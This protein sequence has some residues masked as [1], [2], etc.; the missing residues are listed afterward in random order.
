MMDC[1]VLVKGSHT[2]VEPLLWRIAYA[3]PKEWDELDTLQGDWS[4]DRE[5]RALAY[6]EAERNEITQALDAAEITYHIIPEDQPDAELLAKLQNAVTSK[7][8]ALIALT[9]GNIPTTMRTLEQRV[10]SLEAQIRSSS[11]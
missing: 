8:E 1:R 3:R 4:H 5:S 6:T 2:T 11:T 10:A 7:S 9:T